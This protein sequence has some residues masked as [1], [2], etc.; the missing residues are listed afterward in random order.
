[1][2]LP[3]GAGNGPATPEVRSMCNVYSITTNR[4][5]ICNWGTFRVW[6]ALFGSRAISVLRPLSGDKRK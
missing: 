4:A 6:Q 3:I 5:S 2:P 1:M